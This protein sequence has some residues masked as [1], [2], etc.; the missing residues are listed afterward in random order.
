M[1]ICVVYYFFCRSIFM[2]WKLCIFANSNYLQIMDN[3]DTSPT[4]SEP[5]VLY[6]Q[7]NPSGHIPRQGIPANCMTVDEYFDGLIAEIHKEYARI[8]GDI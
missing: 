2:S 5:A 4:A 3:N 7:A 6:G 8:R 1:I